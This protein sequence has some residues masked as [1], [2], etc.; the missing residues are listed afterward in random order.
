VQLLQVKDLQRLDQRLQCQ[1]PHESIVML[2]CVS[3]C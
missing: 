2:S 3:P 1:Q